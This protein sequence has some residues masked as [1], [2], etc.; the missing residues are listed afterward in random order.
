MSVQSAKVFSTSRDR[1]ADFNVDP[2]MLHI[3]S[4][5][6]RKANAEL[7]ELSLH[8][9]TSLSCPDGASGFGVHSWTMKCTGCSEPR[10]VRWLFAKKAHAATACMLLWP[11]V[12]A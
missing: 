1:H 3:V 11:L 7:P 4:C 2:S 9:G 10:G 5:H 8:N 12:Q 6:V